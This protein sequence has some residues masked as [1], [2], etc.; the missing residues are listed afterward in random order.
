MR[1]AAIVMSVFLLIPS[2]GAATTR[3]VDLLDRMTDMKRLATLPQPGETCQ[4]FSSY[5]RRSVAPDKPNWGANGDAGNF[6]R[7]DPEGMVLAD[8]EGPGCIF[9]IW[10]ANPEGILKVF[11]DRQKEAVLQC[12]FQDIVYGKVPPFLGPVV[13]RRTGGANL[14]FPIPYQKHCR[15]VVENPKS[16]YYHVTYRTY[17]KGTEIESFHLPLRPEELAK[18]K[19]LIAQPEGRGKPPWDLRGEE[20]GEHRTGGW[21]TYTILPGETS[22]EEAQNDGPP[23]AIRA[24]RFRFLNLPEDLKERRKMLART[25]LR[26]YWDN[27]TTPSVDVPLG[28]FFGTAPGV[29]LYKSLPLGIDEDGTAYCYWY[30]PCKKAVRI[31]VENQG[32]KAI[33]FEAEALFQRCEIPPDQIAYFHAK[34]HRDYP[35]K[36]FDWPFL[37]CKGRG[38]FCGAVLTIWNPVRGWWGE[39]D[40]KFWVDGESFPSTFGTGS[41]DYF[42]YAWCGTALF[43]HAF[44]NQTLCEGPGN[45][46]YT[47]VNR[48]HI[49]DDIPFQKSFKGTIENYGNDKDYSCVTYWY[50]GLDQEDSFKPVNVRDRTIHEPRKPFRI[51]GAIEGETLKI[52]GKSDDMEAGVQDISGFGEFSNDNQM[53]FRGKKVGSSA[54]VVFPPVTPGA[55]TLTI[56]PVTAPD[57]GLAQLSVNGK[58]VGSP[59]DA[60]TPRVIRGKQIV[61]DRVALKGRGDV[62]RVDMVGKNPKSTGYF[63]GIDAIKLEPLR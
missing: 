50:A 30:M 3:Y 44:H 11:I 21:K 18:L 39:G 35:N 1:K 61:V 8:M 27:E 25:I 23:L 34:W 2:I 52:V 46:N 12:G 14:Y 57:Y 45:G 41:E 51:E 47:S 6:L 24:M 4:Q 28:D 31:E 5:D 10:S 40:E 33:T 43:Q 29:N 19:E 56:F 53:W 7:E 60:Y 49:A 59:Y 62:L 36:T 63:F 9:R 15:V 37:E 22:K 16:L 42:G 38:R 20:L 17:P 58:K 48:W 13:G 54:E 26:L 32:E 55:S